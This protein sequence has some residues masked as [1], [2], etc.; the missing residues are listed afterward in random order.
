MPSS[1][2]KTRDK[3]SCAGEVPE[4]RRGK[5]GA[6]GGAGKKKM[7]IMNVQSRNVYENK[8]NDDNLPE[9]KA[10]FLFKKATFYAKAH[11]FCRNRRLLCH[12][13]S[14]QECISRFEMYKLEAQA[15]EAVKESPSVSRD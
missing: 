4:S 14:A 5:K 8:E 7:L 3:V 6:R 13:S 10:T 15:G 9:K 11:V 12:F 2:R 1:M